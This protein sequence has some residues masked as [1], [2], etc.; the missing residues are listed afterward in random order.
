LVGLPTDSKAG[1][2]GANGVVA[3][4]DCESLHATVKVTRAATERVLSLMAPVLAARAYSPRNPYRII[5][6]RVAIRANN[7]SLR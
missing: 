4:G 5:D 2:L 3:G 6:H 7:G 1:A